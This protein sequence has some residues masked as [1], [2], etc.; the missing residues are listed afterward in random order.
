M[1]PVGFPPSNATDY[2]ALNPRKGVAPQPTNINFITSNHPNLISA[3]PL[4]LLPIASASRLHFEVRNV[5]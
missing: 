2:N 1:N 4:G 5:G 3:M